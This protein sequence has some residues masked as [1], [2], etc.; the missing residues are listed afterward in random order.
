MKK[1]NSHIV[2]KSGIW[3]TISN[4][5][6]TGIGFITVPIFTRLLTQEEFGAFTNY[7]SWINILTIVFSLN[8][9]AT[10]ISARYEYEE[11]LDEYICSIL[12]LSLLSISFW[13][14]LSNVFADAATELL[15]MNQ[16]YMNAMFLYMFF[17]PA[18]QM[19]Q[20]RERF[21]YRY[22]VS[23]AL[24]LLVSVGGSIL[25]VLLVVCMQDKLTGRILG[26]L[27]PSLAIGLVI[28]IYFYVKGKR[29]TVSFWP[30]ALKIALPYIPHLLS[31]TML[32]QM[33]RVMITKYCGE[34][35]TA[36][37]AL[38]YNVAT[39]VTL[40]QT[41]MN[42]AIGPW[43]AEKI[44]KKEYSEIHKQSKVYV[45][46]F[47]Y[48]AVGLM[49]ISPE[50]LWILGG[51]SYIEA[52][53]V[54][55]PVSL[56]LVCQF[57]YMLFVNV[58]Q[59]SKK[60][61]GM[62]FASISAAVLNFVLNM[63]LIPKFGYIAAAYTTLI[64]YFWLL[65]VHMWL[66]WRLGFSEVYSYRFMFLVLG[67]ITCVSGIIYLLYMANPIRY[68][69]IVLYVVATMIVVYKNKDMI[70]GLFKKE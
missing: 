5:L 6:T 27:L 42:G 60:T 54:M 19:F 1:N 53:W 22:K 46:L 25:S 30:E 15:G 66:V 34:K 11:R 35:E 13:W 2:L 38:A 18:L 40:L 39:V 70:F 3:Y 10:L 31:L 4:F 56:G 49:L 26:H 7:A 61:V 50:A 8:L 44:A 45:V 41:S 47:V 68:I 28:V 59:I 33:D 55:I 32:S 9:Y 43:M 52:K 63:L 65:L 62:A 57:I 14:L 67:V 12:S 48:F 64:G 58:E 51:E 24:S 36:L 16:T 29:I 20:S 69:V 23:T 17:S 21:F 37:Y